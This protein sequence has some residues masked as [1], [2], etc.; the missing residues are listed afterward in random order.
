MTTQLGHHLKTLALGPALLLCL[1][2]SDLLIWST[3]ESVTGDFI[4][5][6]CSGIA[7]GKL[8]QVDTELKIPMKISPVQDSAIC[9]YDPIASV[10]RN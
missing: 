1:G 3:K 7:L 5:S 6:R 4:Q 9:I 2:C 8:E 10:S